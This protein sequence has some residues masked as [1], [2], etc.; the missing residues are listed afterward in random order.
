MYMVPA[1]LAKLQ[2]DAAK[3]DRENLPAVG[4]K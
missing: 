4:V 3:F 2:A 1:E